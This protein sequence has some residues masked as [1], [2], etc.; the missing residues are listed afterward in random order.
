M[1]QNEKN[2]RVNRPLRRA[3]ARNVSPHFLYRRRQHFFSISFLSS[4]NIVLCSQIYLLIVIFR[5]FGINSPSLSVWNSALSR[6]VDPPSLAFG[7][8]LLFVCMNPCSK[9]LILLWTTVGDTVQGRLFCWIYKR[10][11]K[12]ALVVAFVCQQIH[13]LNTHLIFAP[14]LSWLGSAERI[15]KL[16]QFFLSFSLRMN[17]NIQQ[18][19]TWKKKK[20]LY[21]AKLNITKH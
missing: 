19:Y 9:K 15:L 16:A 8:S 1:R 18:S 14:R 3:F 6:L 7:L 13:R 2:R 10:K 21:S 11:W 12:N 4:T 17:T 5:S 20:T